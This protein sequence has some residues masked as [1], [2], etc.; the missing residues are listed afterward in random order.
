[1][2]GERL[3]STMYGNS[4]ENI[5]LEN[6]C[7]NYSENIQLKNEENTISTEMFDILEFHRFIEVIKRIKYFM[8]NAST[9]FG[10]QKYFYA[11]SVKGKFESYN[12][13]SLRNGEQGRI[14]H[15]SL[16]SEMAKFNQKSIGSLEPNAIQ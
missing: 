16:G 13:S 11:N 1:M 2:Y 5:Q 12:V 9:L 15:E 8:A 7:K 10:F 6:G 14:D 3:R 4:L